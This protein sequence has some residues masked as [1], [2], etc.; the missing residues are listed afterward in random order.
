MMLL[1]DILFLLFCQWCFLLPT[2]GGK[3]R[4]GENTTQLQ[5]FFFGN[6]EE[7]Q[8]EYL[9]CTQALVVALPSVPS[10]SHNALPLEPPSFFS[11]LKPHFFH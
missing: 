11:H 2:Q 10:C 7:F 3:P 1:L 9:L 5:R 6:Y 8:V 4:H